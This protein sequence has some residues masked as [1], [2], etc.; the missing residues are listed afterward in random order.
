[1]GIV[2]QGGRGSTVYGFGGTYSEL[3]GRKVMRL[4]RPP[5]AGGADLQ[6]HGCS[7]GLATRS[8][9]SSLP[10]PSFLKGGVGAKAVEGGHL[11]RALGHCSQRAAG[12][13]PGPWWQEAPDRSPRLSTQLPRCPLSASTFAPAGRWAGISSKRL[14]CA[15]CVFARRGRCGVRASRRDSWSELLPVL[16]WTARWTRCACKVSFRNRFWGCCLRWL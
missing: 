11:A 16:P 15:F 7:S 13:R 12:G 14:E 5:T 2:G 3:G 6:S 4:S 9:D 1:M 10:S 8:R